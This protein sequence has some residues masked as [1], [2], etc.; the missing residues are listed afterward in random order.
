MGN[1]WDASA[2]FF[3]RWASGPGLPAKQQ[4]FERAAFLV[5]STGKWVL[6]FGAGSG[7]F[8]RWWADRGARVTA[9]D[10]SRHLIAIARKQDGGRR[11]AYTTVIPAGMFD[12]VFCSMV[13]PCLPPRAAQRVVKQI[14]AR[15]PAGGKAIFVVANPPAIG[16]AFPE[17]S[18]SPPSRRTE[19]AP[20]TTILRM[21]R[22]EWKVRDYYYSGRSLR[23]LYASQGLLPVRE[24]VVATQ[25]LL[26]IALKDAP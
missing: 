21:G 22:D 25:Y 13:L 3:A 23:T 15:L 2:S 10:P 24:E 1:P 6:D 5:S 16:R 14:A 7:V 8:S 20:Y 17:C 18:S 12:I 19:G 4:L 9:H 11:I 26:Q